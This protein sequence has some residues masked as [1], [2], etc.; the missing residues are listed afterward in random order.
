[1]R[2]RLSENVG[3]H[4]FEFPCGGITSE[5][6]HWDSSSW[7]KTQDLRRDLVPIENLNTNNLLLHDIQDG[8]AFRDAKD[9]VSMRWA[10]SPFRFWN[11]VNRRAGITA[12]ATS[13]YNF[14]RTDLAGKLRL[15]IASQQGFKFTRQTW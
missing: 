15:V 1:M 12:T 5:C 10:V 7:E 13:I 3:S 14:Q 6:D 4:S 8:H 2:A 9:D 11:I